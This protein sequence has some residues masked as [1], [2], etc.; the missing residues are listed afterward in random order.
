MTKSSFVD[1][2]SLSAEGLSMKDSLQIQPLSKFSRLKRIQ[3]LLQLQIKLQIKLAE[4]SNK[5]WSLSNAF[6][7]HASH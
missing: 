7:S 6:L 1:P 2:P 5:P 4:W 3:L